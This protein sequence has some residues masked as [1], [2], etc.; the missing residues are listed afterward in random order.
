MKT[1]TAGLLLAAMACAVL[2]A[3]AAQNN[4]FGAL[5]K[6]FQRNSDQEV[7]RVG[8]DGA[9]NVA[10]SP[11]DELAEQD[12]NSSRRTGQ[13][14]GA[15]I[16]GVLGGVLGRNR[17]SEAERVVA[18]V[19]G[20]GAGYMLGGRVG[21]AMG[22][23]AAERRRAYAREHEFLEAEIAASERA[24]AAQQQS[25]DSTEEDIVATESRIAQLEDG[26]DMT[27]AQLAEART[28]KADLEQRIAENETLMASYQE[29]LTYLTHVLE[30]SEADADATAEE[31]AMHEQR[32]ATLVEKKDNL[33]A[34]YEGL[35]ARNGKLIASVEDLEQRGV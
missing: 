13:T 4:P 29:K 19:G 28:L 15:V 22:Q 25:I 21:E 10:P 2:P 9:M 32:Y 23:R 3:H 7:D 5:G 6:M 24:I 11:L 8:E 1:I 14:V 12:V 33:L 20:A 30:T 31:V 35:E 17:D 26:S 34:Q 18:I 27:R 16:G